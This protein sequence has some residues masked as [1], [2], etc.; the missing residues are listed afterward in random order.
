MRHIEMWAVVEKTTE[1]VEDSREDNQK[2]PMPI[3]VLEEHVENPDS[4]LQTVNMCQ[5]GW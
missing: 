4:D 5:R 2:L 1:Q 3:I